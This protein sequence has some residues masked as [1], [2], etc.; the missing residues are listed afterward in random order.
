MVCFFRSVCLLCL[1]SVAA[2]AG[3]P[4]TDAEL[5]AVRQK[6][7]EHRLVLGG[8]AGEPEVPDTYLPIP[9]GGR[10]LTPSEAQGAFARTLPKIEKLRWWRIGLDP[11]QLQHA[12]REP[13]AVVSGCAAACRAKLDGAERGLAL[14]REAAEFL[15]WAQ[16]QAGAGLYPF[17][18]VRGGKGGKAFVAAEHN[19]ADAER[20]GT[21]AR[22]ICNGWAIDDGNNGGLQFDNGEAGVAILELYAVTRDKRHLDSALRAAEWAAARPIAANWNYN[23]FSVYLLAHAYAATNRPAYLAAAVRKARLGVIP[24]QMTDGP[25]AGRWADPHNAKPVYHYIMLRALAQLAAVLPLSDPARPEVLRAL[26][27]GLRA[28]NPDFLGPGACDRNKAMEALL[29][30][31]RTL[32]GEAELTRETRSTD[33]LEALASLVSEEYRSGKL[34]LGPREWGLYLEA[35]ARR[36]ADGR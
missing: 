29:L 35:A 5:A 19:Y 31:C 7:A 22:M 30:V 26:G 33:A 3:Q 32:K 11:A 36:P 18:Y 14:A 2:A 6:A 1:S 16:E 27:L 10:W 24:G 28:R 17:P 20:R 13:A 9:K 21:L 12:L 8:R 34:S 15:L 25:R 4:A 23:S